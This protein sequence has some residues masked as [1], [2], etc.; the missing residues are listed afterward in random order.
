MY[1]ALESTGH[2]GSQPSPNGRGLLVLI[3][4]LKPVFI[5]I[6]DSKHRIDSLAVIRGFKA[7][8]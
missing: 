7:S 2:V 8:Q 1:L 3:I 6:V 4:S 5:L